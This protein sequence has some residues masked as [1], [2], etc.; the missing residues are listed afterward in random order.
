MMPSISVYGLGIS[1]PWLE[2]HFCL[3]IQK[4]SNTIS[5]KFRC[6][7]TVC[8][9]INKVLFYTN[10]W[11][12][13]FPEMV[14]TIFTFCIWVMWLYCC[15]FCFRNIHNLLVLEWVCFVMSFIYT[16]PC[17]DVTYDYKVLE[18][19]G[20]QMGNQFRWCNHH[21]FVPRL[22]LAQG[23]ALALFLMYPR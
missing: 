1:L 23:L 11:V 3:H 15:W 17:L 14:P 21:H 10:W 8:G 4:C 20:A 12:I 19:T 7:N 6:N 22:A 5:L 13:S 16:M 18:Y 2:V 9:L